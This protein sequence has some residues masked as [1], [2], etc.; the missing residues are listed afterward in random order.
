MG[1]VF[2]SSAIVTK[3]SLRFAFKKLCFDK[4]VEDISISDITKACGLN[5]QSFY[6][7]FKD[8]QELISWIYQTEL[9]YKLAH[10]HFDN[11]YPKILDFL[12][13][14]C[15][16]KEFYSAVLQSKDTTFRDNFYPVMYKMFAYSFSKV[17]FP[18]NKNKNLQ[19]CFAN[20]YTHGFCGVV[21]DWG[22]NGMTIPPQQLLNNIK[23]LAYLNTQIGHMWQTFLK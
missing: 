23:E 15:I 22:A 9:F 7:H 8:K 2:M 14:M 5:R 10:T 3:N 16:D 17:D 13:T 20:Y 4:N 19:E 12:E 21:M 1:C 18:D 11:W 6:Y